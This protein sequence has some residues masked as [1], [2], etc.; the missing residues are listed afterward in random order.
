MPAEIVVLER[1]EADNPIPLLTR[2]LIQGDQAMVAFVELAK[3]C[4]VAVHHHV[5]EQIAYIVSGRVKWTLGDSTSDDFQELIVEGG[6]IVR[7][8]SN[9]PHGVD[10]LEDTV[11]IDVLSPPG[12]MGVDFQ[13]S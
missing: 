5:S 11:I 4:H 9:F 8:P 2:K 3:G 7:L 12:N 10:A 13:K 1:L 6:T